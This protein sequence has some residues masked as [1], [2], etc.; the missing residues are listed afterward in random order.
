MDLEKISWIITGASLMGTWMN[1]NQDRRCF[2]IWIVTNGFWAV[3]NFY[4]EMYSQSLL[5]AVYL[6]LAITGLAK[7]K[8][9]KRHQ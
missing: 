5:F 4:K 7:W 3:F 6:V 1:V 9:K 2:W 8:H